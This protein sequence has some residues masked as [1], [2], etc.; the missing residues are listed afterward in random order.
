MPPSGSAK[1]PKRKPDHCSQRQPGRLFKTRGLSVPTL[2][3]VWLFL[4]YI[5]KWKSLFEGESGGPKK[6][7]KIPLQ[8]L[9][10]AAKITSSA[11]PTLWKSEENTTGETFQS[12]GGKVTFY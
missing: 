11:R 12:N 9:Q 4:V 8:A 7:E 3:W 1:Y 5:E 2:R 6:V 10:A